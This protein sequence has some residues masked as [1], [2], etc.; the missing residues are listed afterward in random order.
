LYSGQKNNYKEIKLDQMRARLQKIPGATFT[1]SEEFQSLTFSLINEG[2]IKANERQETKNKFITK[3]G[4]VYPA[5]RDSMEARRD[6]NT[7]LSQTRIDDLRV[8]WDEAGSLGGTA[9]ASNNH[10]APRNSSGIEFDCIPSKSNEEGFG[11]YKSDGT[12]NPDFYTSVHLCGEGLAAETEAVKL[13]EQEEWMAKV[14]VKNLRMRPHVG[15]S[16]E[17]PIEVDKYKEI[18]H[19]KPMKAALRS[20]RTLTMRNGKQVKLRAMPVS[21]MQ[22]RGGQDG[23]DLDPAVLGRRRRVAAHAAMACNKGKGDNNGRPDLVR[24]VNPAKERPKAQ[25]IIYRRSIRPLEA[26]ERM[27]PL[28]GRHSASH[29]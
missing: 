25:Q 21:I 12:K 3:K 17:K 9:H 11:G 7:Q 10:P 6:P 27:P 13:R 20:L 29:S 23:E 15:N 24:Y 18:L 1:F 26:S 8:P 5:P 4:W 14:V 16:G 19:G 28:F 22:P 2:L